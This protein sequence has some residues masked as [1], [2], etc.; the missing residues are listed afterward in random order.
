MTDAGQVLRDALAMLRSWLP[1]K[2]KYASAF[3]APTKRRKEIKVVE[4]LVE[5]MQADGISEFAE[6][7]NSSADPP[8]CVAVDAQGRSIAIEVTEFVSRRAVERNE[9]ERNALNPQWVY[10]DW[11][12]EEIGPE[13]TRILREKDACVLKGGPHA[14]FV[15]VIHC[16][17]PVIT[18]DV[19]Y[20]AL[21]SVRVGGLVQISDAFLL[22]QYEAGLGRWP[23]RRIALGTCT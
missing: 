6:P 17:E 7:R 14:R 5:S 21:N 15:I 2:R 4:L 16:A 11:R 3:E 19:T 18:S 22:L 10:R 8:D 12:S 20:E 1:R 13:I 9:R 23:Y